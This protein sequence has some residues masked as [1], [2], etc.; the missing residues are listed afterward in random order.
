MRFNYEIRCYLFPLFPL[1][2]LPL[3]LLLLDLELERE[4]LDLGEEERLGALYD[5]RFELLLL[6][7]RVGDERFTLEE[8]FLLLDRVGD[9]R[10]TL[11]ELF[12]LPLL[13]DLMAPDFL[14]EL[15][16]EFGVY[17]RDF[18][19][20]EGLLLRLLLLSILFVGLFFGVERNFE[21]GF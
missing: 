14:S 7:E 21:L 20:F 1:D 3:L 15:F 4:G 5:E 18:W 13:R 12:L 16:R 9:E 8:L 6:L 11:E 17:E 10:F 2:E 19:L